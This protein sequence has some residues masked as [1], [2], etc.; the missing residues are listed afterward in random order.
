MRRYLFN[1]A[2]ERDEVL[3]D[4]FSIGFMSA[5]ANIGQ[6]FKVDKINKRGR[7]QNRVFKL[8][9]DSLLN[10]D[11]TYIKSEIPFAG[12]DYVSLEESNQQ[13]LVM[14]FKGESH[15]R[16]VISKD[17]V[18]LYRSL[19]SGMERYNDQVEAEVAREMYVDENT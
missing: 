14:K 11:G 16:K 18:E 13:V 9:C 6:D 4:I 5:G 3:L 2:Q 12:I 7:H 10:M 19:L 15:Q 8:T 17:A 1:S